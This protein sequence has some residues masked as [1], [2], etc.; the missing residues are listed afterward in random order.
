M[1]INDDR[2][3]GGDTADEA[4]LAVDVEDEIDIVSDE[5]EDAVDDVEEVVDN[6]EDVVERVE[7]A[8]SGVSGLAAGAGGAAVAV[9]LSVKSLTSMSRSPSLTS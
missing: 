6:V 8:V 3:E 2:E 7:D 1:S 5:G 4:A 9:A